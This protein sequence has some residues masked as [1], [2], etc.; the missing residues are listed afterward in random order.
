MSS[1]ESKPFATLKTLTF[2]ALIPLTLTFLV[3]QILRFYALSIEEPF[4]IKVLWFIPELLALSGLGALGYALLG[5]TRNSRAAQTT[6][7]TFFSIFSIFLLCLELAAVNFAFVTG[8]VLDP[9]MLHYAFTNAQEAWDLISDSTPLVLKLVIG[10]VALVG[11]SVPHLLR[12]KLNE[13]NVS[14]T[15]TIPALI[16]GIICTILAFVVARPISTVSYPHVMALPGTYAIADRL[17]PRDVES[18]T[19]STLDYSTKDAVLVPTPK[20]K[21]R[22]V[23]LIL[24]ESTR[25]SATTP[26]NPELETTPFL[27][28]LSEKSLLAEQAYVVTPHTSKAVVA[29]GCG[30]D[31]Y[32]GV[33]IFEAGQAGMPHRC[34]AN[35]FSQAGYSTAFFQSAT[36]RF[37]K[38]PE[39]VKN[40]GFK[41][42]YPLEKLDKK[43][44]EKANYFGV[45]DNVMLKPSVEW[46]KNTKNSKKPFFITYLTLT[47]HHDY[48]AP[49]RY[50]RNKYVEEEELNRYLNSVN[51]VDHFVKNVFDEFKKN[52]LYEDTVF[53][54][55]G[56]HGEGFGEHGRFQHDKVIYQEGLTIPFII[57]DPKNPTP[58]RIKVPVN[59]L[60][61]MPT[62]LELSHHRMLK[63]TLPGLSLVSADVPKD[64]P[65]K[66]YCWSRNT[67]MALIREK[68]KYIY[69][70]DLQP[71][72][73]YDLE[74][75]PTEKN[76]IPKN[77]RD[78]DKKL[79]LDW[80]ASTNENY[81]NHQER[82]SKAFI[83]ED[84]IKAPNALDITFDSHIKLY[85]Y[86]LKTEPSGAGTQR[87]T[88]TMYFEVLQDIEP[89]WAL[90]LHGLAK[91]GKM[92]N[93][94]HIPVAGALPVDQFKKGTFIKD[95]FSFSLD[96]SVPKGK[97]TIK[98]GF[99]HKKDGRMP[100]FTPEGR[101]VEDRPTVV[102]FDK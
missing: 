11:L 3:S 42:F 95:E 61:L 4:F 48:L 79:L 44:F 6:I 102:T 29:T 39:L 71:D 74:Q 7:F 87:V 75:D 85:G 98:T 80:L 76:S 33:E 55:L 37:E 27:K 93:L 40:M 63:G 1:S 2:T 38:R 72:E 22:N 51:Y 67:C 34:M 99:W 28:E 20:T 12:R 54:I 53:A 96:K 70:F 18:G 5:L 57:H 31:P 46:A 83:S 50:G 30:V 78:E 94:D 91:N 59:Q 15:R 97:Y 84:R 43:G 65:I 86:D 90:F 52:G 81:K 69:F 89:G 73:F 60:D 13:F 9:A 16:A 56:D 17:L 26:Y 64:R 21:P 100:A 62:L 49:R 45:E 82:Y 25:A 41:E 36:Q 10:L 68:K 19:A 8:S 101:A 58:T 47:P 24:M 88:L 92:R 77:I 14:Y 23:V 66:S 32:L 35:L